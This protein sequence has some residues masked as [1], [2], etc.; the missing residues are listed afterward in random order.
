MTVEKQHRRYS[1]EDAKMMDV[2]HRFHNNY[3]NYEGGFAAL[4]SDVFHPEFHIKFG[5]KIAEA[6]DMPSDDQLRGELT[7]QTQD[8]NDMR[9]RCIDT[10]GLTKYYIKKAA[11]NDRGF[12]NQFAFDNLKDARQSN[13]RMIAH[14]AKFNATVEAKRVEL[15]AAKMPDHLIAQLAELEIRMNH[16]RS[17]QVQAEITREDTTEL[18]VD[19]LNSIWDTMVIMA[20]ANEH[21]HR[22]DTTAAR[23][24][25]LPRYNHSSSEEE[26]TSPVEPTEPIA[27]F[28]QPTHAGNAYGMGDRVLFNANVYESVLD[29]NSWSPEAHPSGWELVE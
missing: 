5:A 3:P 1:V 13:V 26:D 23:I 16:E 9:E 4:D 28:V 24:F 15:V 21:A 10:I 18:R 2:S 6:S 8:V 22:G 20:D 7:S 29:V 14:M 11:G 25:E 12:I 27:E 19:L 17:E